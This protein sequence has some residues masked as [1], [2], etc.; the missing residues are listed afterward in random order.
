MNILCQIYLED[1]NT[2]FLVSPHPLL[3]VLLPA[4]CY[5]IFCQFKTTVGKGEC[6][7]QL[8]KACESTC[9]V[10][11]T[12]TLSHR[13]DSCLGDVPPS[14]SRGTSRVSLLWVAED[15]SISQCA[16]LGGPHSLQDL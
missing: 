8:H 1:R 10:F 4:S 6:N 3:I 11:C 9:S 7:L 5:P 15:M 2:Y 12:Q 13:K 16:V 14:L